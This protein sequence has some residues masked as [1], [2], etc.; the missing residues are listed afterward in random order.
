MKDRPLEPR[1]GC[2]LRI[3]MQRIA[4]AVEAVQERGLRAGRERF[5]MIQ[6][7]VGQLMRLGAGALRAAESPSP[8]AIIVMTKLNSGALSAADRTVISSSSSAPLP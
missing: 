2:G 8:R 6:W 1:P 7:P 4:V 3:G 5:D